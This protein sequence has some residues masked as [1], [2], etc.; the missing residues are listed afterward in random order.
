MADKANGQTGAS[1]P[2]KSITQKEAVR[3]ALAHFGS[4]AMPLQMQ[5]WIKQ[6]FGIDLSNNHISTYKGEIRKQ[7]GKAKAPATAPKAAAAAAPVAPKPAAPAAKKPAASKPAPKKPSAPQPKAQQ[8]AARSKALPKGGRADR[9]ISLGDIE[10]VKGLVG[11]VGAEQLR[12]LID[13][14]AK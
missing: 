5:P 2:K 12:S 6:Q 1:T 9:G 13:L 7:A 3:R 14:L 10:A 8:A 4:D 11:R